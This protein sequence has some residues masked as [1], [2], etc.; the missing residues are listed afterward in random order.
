MNP[1]VITKVGRV[2]WDVL[3]LL[4]SFS[5]FFLFPSSLFLKLCYADA[6]FP[7]HMSKIMSSLDFR[8]GVASA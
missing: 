8:L 5:F 6:P 2:G 7:D 4:V 1:V 3:F